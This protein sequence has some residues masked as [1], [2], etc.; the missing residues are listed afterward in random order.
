MN[1]NIFSLFFCTFLLLGCDGKLSKG[2]L[3]SA[4]KTEEHK[5]LYSV[6]TMFG[7]RIKQLSFDESETEMIVQG[8]RDSILGRPL[9]VKT[10]DYS[11]KIQELF[12]DRRGRVSEQEK[13]QGAI[14]MEKFLKEE[15][16]KKTE[17]GLAYKVIKP[18]VGKKP[19]QDD[20]VKVHYEGKLIDGTVFDS[21]RERDK[22]VTFPLGRVIKGW[23]EG[24]QL[25][26]EGGSIQLVVP[27]SLAY[28]DNGAPPKIPGGA[29]LVFD[30]E[31]LKIEV[32]PKSKKS[33]KK[34]KK[35]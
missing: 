32:P 20:T 26:E 12:R 10:E 3:A 1:R 24:L 16:S 22:P 28:G 35:K 8:V 15:G 5:T 9:V 23:G 2:G 14:Y 25:I 18:G 4:P 34:K 33:S 11:T 6:G 7:A 13:K 27:S 21:S 19:S 30:V 17:S 29:T 31:L